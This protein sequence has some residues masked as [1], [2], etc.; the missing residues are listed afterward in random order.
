VIG[1]WIA[2]VV[3]T[4]IGM[5]LS[6]KAATDSQIFDMEAYKRFFNRIF[7]RKAEEV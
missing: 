2:I 1:S 4:P 7:K 5:F 6:Y 3:I